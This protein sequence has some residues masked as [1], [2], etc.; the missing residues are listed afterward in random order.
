[1][2]FLLNPT[3]GG[4]RGLFQRNG[5]ALSVMT[6]CCPLF[7]PNKR[8]YLLIFDFCFGSAFL[9]L[10]LLCFRSCQKRKR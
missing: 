7:A 2:F 10:L 8:R 6:M 3:C 4:L 9:T 5:G 1:M